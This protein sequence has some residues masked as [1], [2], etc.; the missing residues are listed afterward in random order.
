M[1]EITQ[2]KS[3]VVITWRWPLW[4]SFL[5][6][7]LT[8]IVFIFL[9]VYLNQIQSEIIN[10]NEQIKT[11]AGKVNADDQNAV[12]YLDNSLDAFSGIVL[13]HTYFSS[14]MDLISSLTHSKV[15]LT[16]F[17]A[18]NGKSTAVQK[19]STIQVEGLAQNYTTLAKQ[20]VALRENDNVKSLDVEG[21]NFGTTGVSFK[22]TL[23][24]D[25][26]IFSKK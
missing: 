10:I 3:K 11:E 22:L 16:K 19:D 2:G 6:F 8:I 1:V 12:V 4:V 17:Y 20:M 14:T 7:L 21:I 24:V 23:G 5:L 9:K 26:K 13:N 15:V 18:D 25:P